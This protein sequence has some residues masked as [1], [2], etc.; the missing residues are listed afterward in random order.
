[1]PPWLSAKLIGVLGAALVLLFLVEERARWMHRAHVA[2]AQAQADCRATRAASGVKNLRCDQADEQ[3]GFMGQ[4]ITALSNSIATQNAAV[5][6]LGDRSAAEQA[7]AA[8]ASQ[9]AQNRAKAAEGTAARLEASAKVPAKSQ[10]PCEPSK[11]LEGA[12]K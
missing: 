10:G 2:E 11:A 7:E 9:A 1:M 8:K 4:T 5:K 12:W 6:A 3:I